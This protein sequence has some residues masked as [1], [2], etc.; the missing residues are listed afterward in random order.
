MKTLLKVVIFGLIVVGFF[1]GYANFGVPRIEPAS[2]PAPEVID[3]G[4]MTMEDFVA[5]G[6]KIFNGKGTCT[7]CHNAVGGRAPMLDNLTSLA[8][9]RLADPRYQGEAGDLESYLYESMVETSAFVVAG[10]GKA[11]SGDT[12][13]PMPDVTAGGIG[14]S[15][16]ELRAVIA[17]LEDASGLDV[18]VS[19]P[20]EAKAVVEDEPEVGPRPPFTNAQAII[21]ELMCG[22]CH[23]VAGEEGELGPDLTRIGG[24]RD[25]DYLRRAILEPNVEITEG[26]LPDMM[27]GDYGQQ[28]YAGELEML[29]EYLAASGREDQP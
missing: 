22:A 7:L 21:A 25:R 16:A 4:A 24:L 18:T 11:G 20:T 14:L 6:E 3:L 23:R 29:V 27:P 26:F 15:E 5:L 9:E 2:P 13:S 12:I 17:Y 8:A 1:A 19:I 28:L 10:F